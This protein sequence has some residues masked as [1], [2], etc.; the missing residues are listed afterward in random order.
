MLANAA[1]MID[2]GALVGQAASDGVADAILTA[3][4]GLIKKQD[5]LK[6]GNNFCHVRFLAAQ[7]H[8][9]KKVR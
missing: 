3:I 5:G 6:Q 8:R 1:S 7:K 2:V 4:V 9:S